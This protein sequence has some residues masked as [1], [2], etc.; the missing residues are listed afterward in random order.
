MFIQLC[1]AVGLAILISTIC[2]ILEAVLYSVPNSHLEILRKKGSTA[3]TTIKELKKDI[4]RP[5]TAILTLNTVAHTMGAAVAGAAAA[6]VFGVQNLVWFSAI[7]TL[8]ILIFSEILPKTAGVA[9]SKELVPWIAPPLKFMVA[10]LQPAIWFCQAIT[11]LIPRRSEE[12]ITSAEEVM[13]I[14]ALSRRAGEIDS[15]EENVITNILEL[16]NKTVKEAMTPRTV[17]FV[18][19]DQMTVGEATDIK[20]K[21]NLH[22]RVPVYSKEPDNISGIVLR[23]DVLS[24]AV[25]DMDSMALFSL[26]LPVIFVPETAPLSKVLVN[27]INKRQ[28]LFVVVDEYG[29]MTGVISLE[30]IIEEI[31]G[32]EIMDESDQIKDMRALAKKQ[33]EEKARNGK[34]V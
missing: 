9:Y 22:S 16:K 20:E 12:N 24:T 10:I 2:S 32:Q 30:D 25:D 26:A 13:A 31:F 4:H 21:W 7:F 6:S 17:T 18:L 19:D 28:H 1:V 34:Q 8:A 14:A 5:I 27:F 3:A 29:S 23:K 15:Q 33:R 11:R